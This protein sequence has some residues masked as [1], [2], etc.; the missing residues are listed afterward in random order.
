ML[1]VSSELGSMSAVEWGRWRE[2]SL[3]ES[4]IRIIAKLSL[5]TILLSPLL[6]CSVAVWVGERCSPPP[7]SFNT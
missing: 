4:C 1:P 6:V 7:P 5:T 2:D 3:Y